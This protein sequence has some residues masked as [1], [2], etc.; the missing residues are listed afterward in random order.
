ML[1][2]VDRHWGLALSGMVALLAF[3]ALARLDWQ[4][5]S[6]RGAQIPATIG[7]YLLAFAAFAGALAWSERHRVPMRWVWAAAVI[8]RLV[9]LLTTPTLSDDVYR[10]LWDGHVANHGVSP[11]AYAIDSPQ[12]DSLDVTVRNRANNRWMASPYLPA[13]QALFLA[14]TAL[15]PLKPIFFQVVM[16]LFDLGSAWLIA[17]LL[18]L[19]ELPA[20][21]LILYLWNPLVVV[22][23]AHG[24]HIDAWMVVLALLSITLT[25]RRSRFSLL[26]SW[27]L[28]PFALALAT[29]TKILPILLLPLLFS[30]WEW[31]QRILY[32]TASIVLL[33]PS[34]LRAG[35]G[36]TGELTGRG[37]FGALRIYSAQWNFNSG[38]FHW[39]EVILGAPGY[40]PP[41]PLAKVIV[42]L[43]MIVVSLIVWWRARS[44]GRKSPELRSALRLMAVPLMAYLLLSPTVH[45]WYALLLLALVPFLPPAAGE[46][47]AL[48]LT[49]LPWIYLSGALV[50]SYLTYLDPQNFAEREWVRQLEWVPT[51]LLILILQ[52]SRI[53]GIS[54]PA[55]KRAHTA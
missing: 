18:A 30:Y 48:W 21:R 52:I 54:E 22:E 49:A 36:L 19:A 12:L 27:P 4:Y 15:L 51:L 28:A 53:A 5:G 8:F 25:L 31:R 45:P 39:L 33:I 14:V 23:V 40:G 42:T 37:L 46:S 47:R 16:V 50:F 24:A 34:G 7:W 29:L 9:L 6:L 38:L 35:W 32:V 44:A 3:V 10:Y 13:G 20:H 1:A 55:G 43:A 26:N 17:H 11:Y 2:K 41:S